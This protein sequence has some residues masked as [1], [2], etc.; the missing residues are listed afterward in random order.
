MIDAGLV[1]YWLLAALVY[2]GFLF[3]T[4]LA[5]FTQYY[6]RKLSARFQNRMGPS[7]VGPA[8]ILQPLYD[9][10]KLI[11]VKEEVLPRNSLPWIGRVAGLLGLGAAYTIPLLLPL[12]IL[13]IHG[14]Y[15]FLV[16]MYLCCLWIPFM[17]IVMSLSFPGPY[18]SVGVSRILTLVTICEPAYFA[19]MLVPVALT[20]S[21]GDPYSV[22]TAS[23][24]A[25]KLWLNPYTLPLM[26]LSLLAALV[27][28]QA[29]AMYQPFNIPE[30]EQE[31]IAG[32]E[33]EFSGPILGL[34]S[35][36]HDVDVAIT[37]LSITY[38]ILGGPYPYPHL[39]IPGIIVLIAKYLV[40]MFLAVLVKNL[41]GRYRIEQALYTLFKYS[42][43]P[44]IIALTLAYIYI[45]T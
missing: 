18:T 4:S 41:Y 26:I 15:D 16:Y 43:I 25:W 5:L 40:V 14:P 23:L 38:I 30:A 12:S 36:L 33:T 9:L 13:R 22:Y 8:G 6:T 29:K 19:S 28:L 17:L 44:A 3:L 24:N 45:N 1:I 10:L 32:F 7:Y 2:P 27:S 31:I 21:M 35:L 42:F 39:S 34:G 11:R 20:S 37:A